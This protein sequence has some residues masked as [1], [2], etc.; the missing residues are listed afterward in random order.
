MLMG[1]VAVDNLEQGMVISEDVRDINTRLLLSK[2][3]KIDPKH[4]RILKIWG[5]TEVNVVGAQPDRPVDMPADDPEKAMRVQ[6]ALDTVF[7]HI[8]LKNQILNE[9]YRASKAYR[10]Q[11][12]SEPPAA[13]DF[14]A[15]NNNEVLSAPEKIRQQIQKIDAK[16]PEAPTII[17][18][19]NDVIADP[20]ATSNDVAQVVNKSPS[21]AALLLKIVNSAY[22]GFPSRIDRI[23]RA[24]TIIG[25]KEISGLAL[26]ICVMRAFNDIP[27]GVIDMQAF[28][29]HS[30]ACGMVARILGALK[31]MEQT[32]QLFVSGLLHDIGKLIVFKYFPEYT[33]NYMLLSVSTGES[34]F[35][36]EKAVLGL[37]HPQI[38]QHLLRKWRLPPELENNVVFHHTPA[39]APDSFKAGIMQLADLIANGL[40]I[41]TSGERMIPCCD[42]KVLESIGVSTSTL[43]MVIRQA[44]HQLGPMEAVFSS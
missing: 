4:I 33:Q 38:G 34:V 39:K 44:I 1:Y 11:S 35:S 18:E 32:E 37:S 6:A 28:I 20:F 26:G 3:Q 23:S 15:F 12:E 17:S 22:Y 30:L 27:A 41:G 19:L 16:L 7:R 2:G 9:I 25:T 5:V 24:V 8:N 29:R 10:L 36:A 14:D 43:Q 31:N 42:E 21:L 13:S 40:G